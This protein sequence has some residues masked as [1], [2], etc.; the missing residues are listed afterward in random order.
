LFI[1]EKGQALRD[2]LQKIRTLQAQWNALTQSQRIAIAKL[3][4]DLSLFFRPKSR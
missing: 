4:P 1:D 3:S 2:Q